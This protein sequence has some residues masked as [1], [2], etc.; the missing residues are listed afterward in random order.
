MKKRVF[1]GKLRGGAAGTAALALLCFG[2]CGAVP[3]DA[4]SDPDR[5]ILGA[6]TDNDNVAPP[7]GGNHAADAKLELGFAAKP[8]FCCNPL[9][10]D[11]EAVATQGALPSG[12]TF[13]WDFGDGTNAR[14]RAVQHTYRWSGS[15]YVSLIAILPGEVVRTTGALVA[16]G[17][18][19]EDPPDDNPPIVDS[20]DDP[21]DDGAGSPEGVTVTADAGPDR[22]VPGGYVV[23]L[24]GSASSGSGMGTLHFTWSQVSGPGVT[25][26][27]ATNAKATFVAPAEQDETVTMTFKLVVSQD[28]S[29]ASDYVVVRVVPR[30]N[31]TVVAAA[32]AD[33]QVVG[34]TTVVLDGSASIT[35]GTGAVTYHWAEISGVFAMLTNPESAITTLMA[36]EVDETVTLV[37]ELTVTQGTAT[38]RD[39]VAVVVV[40]PAAP[41]APDPTSIEALRMLPPLPRVHYNWSFPAAFLNDASNDDRL[42]EWVRISHSGVVWGEL[43]K[44][45]QLQKV[46]RMCREVNATNPAI[47][48]TVGFVFR[49]F[50]N[51]FPPDAPPT[52]TGPEQDEEIA[53]LTER[54]HLLKGWVAQDNQAHGSP[55]SVSCVILGSERFFVKAAG[56]AGAEAWNAAIDAKH[57]LTYLT[58]KQALPQARVEWYA[59][60]ISP[61]FTLREMGEAF[62]APMYHT[63]EPSSLRSIIVRGLAAA[64]AHG[65]NEFTPWICLG[66]SYLWNADGSKTWRFDNPYDES[67]SWQLGAMINYNG[68]AGDDYGI[69]E[70]ADVVIHWPPPWDSRIA[71]WQAHFVA[72]VLGANGLA[73]FERP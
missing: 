35:Y 55:V 38:G 27:R 69:Q 73:M 62:S 72:Y 43:V 31:T 40:P 70:Y 50:T 51:I 32:G 44:Q 64:Q 1:G 46:M 20:P 36:P 65:V 28:G 63:P 24:D 10:R 56:E 39:T 19:P 21:A 66:T 60:A 12:A 41:P 23:L 34:G 26:T 17:Y 37:F 3:I 54:L 42:R 57:N 48:A 8:I 22:E 33:Q 11:F 49:P 68:Y 13:E 25:L 45:A 53:F 2:G 7:N 59:R 14:G 5:P 58:V 52:Y 6:G 16:V 4:G 71:N 67:A 29:A 18:A 61:L 15:Y 30:S 9:T 47:P